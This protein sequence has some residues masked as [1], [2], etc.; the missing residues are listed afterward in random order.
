[1]KQALSLP[2]VLP[3]FSSIENLLLRSQGL[4]RP[5]VFKESSLE[6]IVYRYSVIYRFKRLRVSVSQEEV[7]MPMPSGR[8][9]SAVLVSLACMEMDQEERSCERF[10]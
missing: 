1:M 9:S 5:V 6:A 8:R 4:V 7:E 2:R 10:F 3:L